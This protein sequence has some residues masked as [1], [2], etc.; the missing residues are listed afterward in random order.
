MRI[1]LFYYFMNIFSIV[2]RQSDHLGFMA[3]LDFFTFLIIFTY[4]P[5][6]MTIKVM[7]GIILP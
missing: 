5:D 1:I 4:F 3:V 2:Y 7:E 6:L